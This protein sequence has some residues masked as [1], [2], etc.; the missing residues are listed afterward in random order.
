MIFTA[1][2]CDDFTL[3]QNGVLVIWE[4]YAEFTS[5]D[6]EMVQQFINKSFE[7]A[8]VCP[9]LYVDKDGMRVKRVI[10]KK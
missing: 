2:I 10:F 4:N 3:D 7:N 5:N 1:Y 9:Q 8:V 6:S